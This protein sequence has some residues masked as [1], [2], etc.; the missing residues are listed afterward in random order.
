M[1]E[2]REVNTPEQLQAFVELP[3]SI[4]AED[5]N[6]VPPLKK[7]VR[8]L[9]DHRRHPFWEH[10]RGTL[11]LAV[12]DGRPVG[13]ISAQVDD[14]YNRL[15][16]E[17]L[18]SFGFF[19]SQDRADVGSALLARASAWVRDRGMTVVRGPM[20]PSS[21]DEWGLLV[22]G[23]D[24]PPVLMMPYNPPYYRAL[25]EGS[26]FV[27]AKDL[28]AFI[29]YASTPMPERFTTLA[30]RLQDNPRISVRHLNM[31]RLESEMKIVK[32][33]YNAAWEKNWG[34]SPM[35]GR[36]MDLLAANLKNFAVPE[37]VLLAFYD[38][39]PAGLSITLPDFNQ[40]LRRLDGRFD[41]AGLLKSLRYRNRI[42]GIRALVF[43]FKKE[44]RRLGLPILLFYRTELYARSKG[45]EWCELSWNLEDN[46][47]I[48]D[49]DRD[50]GG[51]VYKRYRVYEK[52]L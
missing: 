14:N 3:W 12:E 16:S 4:Y 48:N 51:K 33:L 8:E 35:T 39:K 9:L 25:I 45:Y 49:F 7:D 21:N 46:R 19:E 11:F 20:S 26:G 42:T 52:R 10:A 50:L 13:R 34:F 18:G 6:W 24:R 28:L 27:K 44:Y 29:K 15:W 30:R 17:K 36:E 2:V 1:I 40:V 43:G 41:L 47:L 38:G 22:K 37:M 32:E 5:R 31:R 23:F